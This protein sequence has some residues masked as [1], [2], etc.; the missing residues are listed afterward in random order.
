M[1]KLEYGTVQRNADFFGVLANTLFLTAYMLIATMSMGF[2]MK[3]RSKASLGGEI[4][5]FFLDKHLTYLMVCAVVWAVFLSSTYYQ[6][7]LLSRV[8]ED[9]IQVYV[10]EKEIESRI[11]S[12]I[13]A[14]L[15]L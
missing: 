8:E 12:T 11:L 1:K 2:A 13:W 15:V 14:L 3:S 5:I 7:F 10:S 6:M 9:P 4:Q